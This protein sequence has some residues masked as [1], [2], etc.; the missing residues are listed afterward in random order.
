[1]SPDLPGARPAHLRRPGLVPDITLSEFLTARLDERAATL[2][3]IA[4]AR[5]PDEFPNIVHGEVLLIQHAEWDGPAV[6]RELLADVEAKRRIVDEH[7]QREVA[8]LDKETWGRPY[9]VCRRCAVGDRQVVHP[10]TTLRLLALPYAGHPDY[11]AE[12]WAP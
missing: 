6:L 1:M 11:R 5:L 10:C 3:E 2:R 8:S 4:D 12:E 9:L 7:G